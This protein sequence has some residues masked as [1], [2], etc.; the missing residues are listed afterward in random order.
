MGNLFGGKSDPQTSYVPTEVEE[1]K[2]K[3]K[4]LRSTLLRTAGGILGEETIAGKVEK[5]ANIFGNA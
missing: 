4:A 5:R 1:G 2:S 3:T